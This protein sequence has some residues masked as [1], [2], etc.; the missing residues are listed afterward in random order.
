[1]ST[2]TEPCN[3]ATMQISLSPIQKKDK[4]EEKSPRGQKRPSSDV[5]DVLDIPKKKREGLVIKVINKI[6]D[7]G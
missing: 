5:P 2:P 7:L 4:E 6:L 1:M 3:H